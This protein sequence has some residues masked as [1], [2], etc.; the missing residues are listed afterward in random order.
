MIYPFTY[1]VQYWCESV[2]MTAQGITFGENFAAATRN[3]SD[4]YG[5]KDIDRLF[6]VAVED[7]QGVMELEPDVVD[8]I[9]KRAEAFYD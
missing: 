8:E 5:D 6:I 1:H 7:A 2:K 4:F 3:I 9:E